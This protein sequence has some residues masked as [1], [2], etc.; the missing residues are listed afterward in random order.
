MITYHEGDATCP[1]GEGNKFIVHVCN[2]RGGWGAGFVLA[3]SKRWPE[4]ER[5]YRRWFRAQEDPEAGS[6]ALGSVQYVPV[7]EDIC[8]V[9][10]I[11][12]DGYMSRTPLQYSALLECLGKVAVRVRAQS[13][14]VHMPRIGCGLAGGK[15]SLVETLIKR[16]MTNLSVHVYDLPGVTFR[17]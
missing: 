5:A 7:A 8:V 16:T 9:N 15:W 3:L 11:A 14:S 12:Q 17:A 4:P 6:F 1:T 10:M 2:D 13:G